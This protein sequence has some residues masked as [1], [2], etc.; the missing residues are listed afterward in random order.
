[1]HGQQNIKKIPL[2]ILNHC[3]KKR[4]Q[5]FMLC[6][7]IDTIYFLIISTSTNKYT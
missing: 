7:V 5:N 4:S 2:D 1:M 6:Y 3:K